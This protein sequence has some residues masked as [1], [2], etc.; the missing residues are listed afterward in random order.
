VSRTKTATV[1]I[2]VVCS[3]ALFI[4]LAAAI[5]LPSIAWPDEIFQTLEQ[6]HRLVFG[7]GIVPWEFRDGARS[8]IFPGVLAAAMELGRPFG[9]LG[10]LRAAQ[11]LLGL[12]SIVPVGVA[13]AWVPRRHGVAA[14]IAASL[15]CAI[16]FELVYFST[17]SLN[18]V[19]AAHVMVAALFL[20]SGEELG[21]RR[22]LLAGLAFG[23]AV[24]LRIQLAPAVAAALAVTGGR[25]WRRWRLLLAGAAI[26]VLG[27]GLLDLATWSGPFSS[28][29]LNFRYNVI[30]GNSVKF[31]VQPWHGYVTRLSGVWSWGALLV[32]GLAAIGAIRQPAAAAFTVVAFV[33]HSAL[34][35]KEYRFVYP[36]IV[37]AVL[38]ASQ[39]TAYLLA[40]IAERAR[41]SR[42]LLAC[43]AVL[44][45]GAVSGWRAAR[46][47]SDGSYGFNEVGES[48]WRQKDGGLLAM[49]RLGADPEVCGVGLVRAHWA[50]TGGYTYLHRDVPIYMAADGY[51]FRAL[52]P[53]FNAVIVSRDLSSGLPG[54]T[55]EE[56]WRNICLAKRPGTC[57]PVDAPKINQVLAHFGA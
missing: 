41:V 30:E 33:T 34:A 49:A 55:V 35:H 8:W 48:M 45:W 9:A 26:T 37:V 56:C 42:V 1:A 27:A 53:A 51:L 10:H 23:L 4:R 29:W 24:A 6:A 13:F 50:W 21:N 2:A 12:L 39:G 11:I 25:S 38:L 54:Y 5:S 40:W 20:G 32:V 18:E 57:T 17:R 15:T 52:G 36:A 7:Y 44:V 16:W 19:A 28:F 43:A 31:G 14:A 46:F 22:L 47:A 3:V